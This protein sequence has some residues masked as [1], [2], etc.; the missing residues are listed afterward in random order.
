MGSPLGTDTGKVNSI[1]SSMNMFGNKEKSLFLHILQYS[2]WACPCSCFGQVSAACKKL[3]VHCKDAGH[4]IISIGCPSSHALL[5]KVHCSCNSVLDIFDVKQISYENMSNIQC[6]S[7][8]KKPFF[9]WLH[10]SAQNIIE[11]IFLQ[12]LFGFVSSLSL[13]LQLN[14]LLLV[15]T[16]SCFSYGKLASVSC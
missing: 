16:V 13:A 1:I 9:K 6:S 14:I 12:F 2:F 10:S 5:K 15:C 8:C 11:K 3:E 7:N 4:L